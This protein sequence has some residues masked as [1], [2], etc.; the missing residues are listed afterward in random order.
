MKTADLL[1]SSSPPLSEDIWINNLLLTNN[2]S[3]NK[4]A[5][6]TSTTS[7]DALRQSDPTTLQLVASID[8]VHDSVTCLKPFDVDQACVLTAGKDAIVRC[9]DLRTGKGVLDLGNGNLLRGREGHSR[10]AEIVFLTFS[11]TQN[12]IHFS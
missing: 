5:T 8:R 2:T 1:S 10:D 12:T 9:W 7:N 4:H 6:L 3:N 11:R